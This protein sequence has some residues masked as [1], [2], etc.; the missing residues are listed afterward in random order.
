MVVFNGI[1]RSPIGLQFLLRNYQIN[2]ETNDANEGH[3]K[4]MQS[5]ID[6]FRLNIQLD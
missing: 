4:I 2:E 5:S 3:S 6:L 1:Y